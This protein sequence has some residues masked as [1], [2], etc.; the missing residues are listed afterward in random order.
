MATKKSVLDNY[1]CEGQLSLFDKVY[2]VV[3]KGFMSDAYCPK[4]DYCFWETRE[5][6]CDRCPRCGIRVDWKPWH[7]VNDEEESNVK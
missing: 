7:R 4:C 3:V 6:D 5:L 2:P 1:E